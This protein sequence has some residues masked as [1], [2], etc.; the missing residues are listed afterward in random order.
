VKGARPALKYIV[1][2]AAEAVASLNIA[3]GGGLGSTWAPA[4]L[5][6]LR[7]RARAPREQ[8]TAEILAFSTT[9]A[10]ASRA[11]F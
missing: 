8:L 5:W 9:H 3:A 2:E 4:E 7:T 6:R 11:R 10:S 1:H